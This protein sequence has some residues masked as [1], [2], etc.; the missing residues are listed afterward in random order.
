[1]DGSLATDTDDG[2]FGKLIQ[3]QKDKQLYFFLVTIG[4]EVDMKQLSSLK[5]DGTV[6]KASKDNFKG[7]FVWISN[8]L[9]RTS[10]SNPGQKVK[11]PNP[12]NY[13]MEIFT[14]NSSNG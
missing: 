14:I 6:L 5:L 10:S 3:F 8:S 11:L 4:D 12:I 2:V 7:A 1:M 13:N 9:S